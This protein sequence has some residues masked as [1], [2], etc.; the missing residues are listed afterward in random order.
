MMAELLLC[1]FCGGKAHTKTIHSKTNKMFRKLVNT[2]YYV[3]CFTCGCS[4]EVKS[5]KIEAEEIWNT[6]TLKERGER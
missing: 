5:T 4:T 1:P 6:R 3:K 2:Y